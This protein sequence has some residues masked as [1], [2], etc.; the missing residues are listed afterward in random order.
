MT[1]STV[2][3]IVALLLVLTVS[4]LMLIHTQPSIT[5]Q[6]TQPNVIANTNH[7]DDACEWYHN[8]QWW[9]HYN[10]TPTNTSHDPFAHISSAYNYTIPVAPFPHVFATNPQCKHQGRIF[11]IGI[12]KTGT[13]SMM[14]ALK[15][16]GYSCSS[17]HTSR[18]G[19]TCQYHELSTAYPHKIGYPLSHWRAFSADDISWAFVNRSYFQSVYLS[20]SV[21]QIFGD[22]PW[23]FL[24]PL[25]DKWYPNAK[26]IYTMRSSTYHRVNSVIKFHL[27]MRGSKKRNKYIAFM[28]EKKLKLLYWNSELQQM[29]MDHDRLMELIMLMARLYEKHHANALRYFGSNRIGDGMD[30]DVLVLCLECERNP[31]RKIQQFLG[32]HDIPDVAFPHQL[33]AS[34]YLERDYIPRN[35]SLDWR[36]HTFSKAVQNVLDLIYDES[37]DGY[38]LDRIAQEIWGHRD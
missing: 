3:C 18:V 35:I 24:Y 16:F 26:Y 17:L 8:R 22:S 11:N 31:W 6:S 15:Q 29:L 23:A 4:R 37:R 9:S 28:K 27:L 32:C 20:S 12:Q 1:R 21:S 34:E 33:R 5:Y 10:I 2:A 38:K 25:W 36:K 13:S 19:S 7:P 30:K 14:E